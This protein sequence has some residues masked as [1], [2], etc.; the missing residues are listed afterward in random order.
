M[1]MYKQQNVLK[2]FRYECALASVCRGCRFHPSTHFLFNDKRQKS[3]LHFKTQ[4]P[5]PRR[6]NNGRKSHTEVNMG[7]DAI[8]PVSPLSE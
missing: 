4:R 2:H 7:V 1:F 3:S 8:Q 5:E 6:H